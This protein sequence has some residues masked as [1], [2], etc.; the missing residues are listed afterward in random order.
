M[1]TTNAGGPGRPPAALVPR[2]V[3]QLAIA[4]STADHSYNPIEAFDRPTPPRE[5]ATA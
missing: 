4:A 5:L 1:T 2:F 3:G